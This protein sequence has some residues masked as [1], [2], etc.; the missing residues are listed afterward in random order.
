MGA[1]DSACMQNT[2]LCYAATHL[3]EPILS[4]FIAESIDETILIQLAEYQ[5]NVAAAAR[6][7]KDG[8]FADWWTKCVMPD[9]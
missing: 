2:P 7:S 5:D 9:V 8:L 6:E 4:S 1:A 3:A